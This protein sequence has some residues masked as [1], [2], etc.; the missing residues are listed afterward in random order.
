MLDRIRNE[1]IL[2]TTLVS[3]LCVLGVQLGLPISDGL[4]NALSGVIVAG[5]ALFGRSKV[6]PVEDGPAE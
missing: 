3:A 2:V 4:A 1:P 6:T 5:A